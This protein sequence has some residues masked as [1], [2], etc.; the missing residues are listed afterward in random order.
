MAT[1]EITIS[2]AD[3]VWIAGAIVTLYGAFKVLK[4]NPIT[5]HETRLEEL[6]TASESTTEMLEKQA[7]TN[8]MILNSLMVIIEHD[9]TGNGI[10]NM[11]K[12]RDEMHDFLIKK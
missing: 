5:K 12:I 3:F 7:E 6:E 4:D 10:E 11:K 8:K 1:G 9:I 2:L